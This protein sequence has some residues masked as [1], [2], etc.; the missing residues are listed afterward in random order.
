MNDITELT[1]YLQ[2]WN[3]KIFGCEEIL[4]VRVLCPEEMPRSSNYRGRSHA[5]NAAAVEAIKDKNKIKECGRSTRNTPHYVISQT[6]S[7]IDYLT[8]AALPNAE[9]MM[10][11]VRRKSIRQNMEHQY[12]TDL[13]DEKLVLQRP[14]YGTIICN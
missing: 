5:G 3:W 7:N 10:R 11:T 13:A 8:A 12:Q 4:E 6:A 2:I 14:K 9:S 1:A